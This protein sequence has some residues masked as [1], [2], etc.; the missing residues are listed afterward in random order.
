M[1]AKQWSPFVCFAVY[2]A[3]SSTRPAS[4]CVPVTTWLVSRGLLSPT[5]R[6][7]F[8]D[9]NSLIAAFPYSR[10]LSGDSRYL[11]RARVDEDGRIEG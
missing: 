7:S 6:L 11:R 9:V 8:R 5:M 3:S 4:R 1:R 10:R 2:N